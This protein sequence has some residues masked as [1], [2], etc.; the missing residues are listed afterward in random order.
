MSAFEGSGPL[1]R[2]RLF[3][4]SEQLAGLQVVTWWEIRRFAYNVIVGATG[5]ATCTI[6]FLVAF[7][8]SKLTSQ[9][10]G[11]PDPP[12]FALI[13]IVAYGIA[14]NVC[15]TIGWV[16]ELIIGRFWKNRAGAFGEIAF[17]IGVLFSIA[18]TL[19]PALFAVCASLVLLAI[20]NHG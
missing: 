10:I 17:F 14:A 8:S 18:V 1:L 4:R 12:L 15:Y 2:L 7:I 11:W 3:V 20:G 19:T 6:C 13:G 5:I 16:A 9:P